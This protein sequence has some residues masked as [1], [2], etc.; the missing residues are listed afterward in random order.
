MLR[1][2][3][4]CVQWNGE[5]LQAVRQTKAKTLPVYKLEGCS[6]FLL[7]CSSSSPLYFSFF[8]FP[9]VFK[10][11]TVTSNNICGSTALNGLTPSIL[12]PNVLVSHSFEIAYLRWG[13]PCFFYVLFLFPG[14]YCQ[15]CQH[16]LSFLSSDFLRH[17]NFCSHQNLVLSNRA[18]SAPSFLIIIYINTTIESFYKI[19]CLILFSQ[20]HYLCYRHKQITSAAEALLLAHISIKLFIKNFSHFS[21]PKTY[22]PQPQF[23]FQKFVASSIFLF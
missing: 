3:C 15:N 20:N 10:M 16:S 7:I 9:A 8:S 4:E 2:I 12:Q 14:H 13:S 21:N 5:R 11:I 18:S 23:F 6:A 19:P 1:R 17:W 22:S